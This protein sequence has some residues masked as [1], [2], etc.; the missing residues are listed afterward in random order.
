MIIMASTL[1]KAI[2]NCRYIKPEELINDTIKSLDKIP[3]IDSILVTVE[4]GTTIYYL[5]T[6]SNGSKEKYTESSIPCS[7]VELMN[8][9]KP[10]YRQTYTTGNVEKIVFYY[11]EE[12]TNND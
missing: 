7:V 8:R 1:A 4:N 6:Y 2:N 11:R 9:K 12:E 3:I 10:V 5:V